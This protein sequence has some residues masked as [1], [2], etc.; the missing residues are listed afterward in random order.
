SDSWTRAAAARPRHRGGR[1]RRRS[2]AFPPGLPGAR[3]L[4]LRAVAPHGA[5]GRVPRGRQL[6]RGGRAGAGPVA[7][8]DVAGPCWSW[9]RRRTRPR[10]ST[11]C[12]RARAPRTRCASARPCTGARRSCR[13]RTTARGRAPWPCFC[14]GGPTRTPA[15]SSGAPRCCPPATSP[16]DG[17]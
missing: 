15:R 10:T 5:E 2:P 12:W 9:S 4:G 11:T 8:A 3:R 1:A 13:P 14:S 17:A 6:R 7:A 16:G